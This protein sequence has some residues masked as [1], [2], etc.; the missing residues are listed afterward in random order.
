MSE[1]LQAIS[2]I[3]GATYLCSVIV[4]YAIST[5]LKDEKI[6]KEQDR[7]NYLNTL[8]GRDGND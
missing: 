6:K 8:Y 7:I 2:I 4:G 3:L 5:K 1:I